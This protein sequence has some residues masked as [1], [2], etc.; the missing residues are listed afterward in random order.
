MSA[1]EE[2]DIPS[3]TPDGASSQNDDPGEGES[4]GE[5][6]SYTND[7]ANEEPVYDK[8]DDVYRC[9]KL[10]CG[11]EV[12]FGYCHGCQIKYRMEVRQQL[13]CQLPAF[14]SCCRMMRTR[15]STPVTRSRYLGEESSQEAIHF[16]LNLFPVTFAL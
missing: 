14:I 7:Y 9:A 10:G 12:A 3:H 4:D 15:W 6:P 2:E 5:G 1:P 13:L 16:H 11:W 8:A